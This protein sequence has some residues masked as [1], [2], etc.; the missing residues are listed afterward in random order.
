MFWPKF[1][2]IRLIDA[3]TCHGI[4]YA[5]PARCQ[6][7]WSSGKLTSCRYAGGVVKS[8][9]SRTESSGSGSRRSGVSPGAWG[10]SENS[11]TGVRGVRRARAGARRSPRWRARRLTHPV[12]PAARRGAG[13]ALPR[14]AQRRAA[15]RRRSRLFLRRRRRPR[16]ASRPARWRFAADSSATRKSWLVG[17]GVRGDLLLDVTAEDEVDQRLLERLHVEERSPRRSPRRCPRSGSRESARRCA[18]S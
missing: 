1:D 18:R 4:P 12:R 9:G 10:A 13:S 2:S 6:R 14:R 8:S 5:A 7:P 3:S 16:P 15:R 11:I 17:R